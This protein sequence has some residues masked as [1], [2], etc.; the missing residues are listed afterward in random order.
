MDHLR[1][2]GGL[3]N[4]AAGCR[5]YRYPSPPD[6]QLAERRDCAWRATVLV[7]HGPV[8]VAGR[9]VSAAAGIR[10]LCSAGRSVRDPRDGRRRCQVVD[11]AGFVDACHAVCAHVDGDG[12]GR[13]G[14][15]HRAGHVAHHPSSAGTPE[16]PLWRGDRAGGA[17][18]D[19]VRRRCALVRRQ[20]T[21]S[22]RWRGSHHIFG[23]GDGCDNGASDPARPRR[24]T[25]PT[26]RPGRGTRCPGG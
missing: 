11:G 8:D 24:G 15:D 25:M 20:G 9:G 7:G 10:S 5:V 21:S 6:R 19:L 3:G 17:V 18:D 26:T 1:I 12:A 14:A 13:R 2:G 4:R 16:D 22:A 23:S